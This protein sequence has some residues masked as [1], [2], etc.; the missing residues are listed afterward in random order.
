MRSSRIYLGVN[1][2]CNSDQQIRTIFHAMETPTHES[3][4]ERFIYVIGPFRTLAGAEIM[5]QYGR[6]NPHL[7][8]VEDAERM[9]KKLAVR[10]N[11]TSDLPKIALRRA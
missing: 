1:L 8:T 5:R 6:N 9:A 4:G 3:H 10:I 2:D 11:G 7:Q